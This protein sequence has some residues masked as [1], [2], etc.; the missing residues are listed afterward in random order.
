MTGNEF[1]SVEASAR[2]SDVIALLADAALHSVIV[3]DGGRGR[4]LRRRA[5]RRCHIV[6]RGGA[7]TMGGLLSGMALDPVDAADIGRRLCRQQVCEI[8]QLR[9]PLGFRLTACA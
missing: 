9:G 6:R 8:G 1:L 7:V 3:H 2:V 4:L 5:G